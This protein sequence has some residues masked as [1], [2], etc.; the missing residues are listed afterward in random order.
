MDEEDGV[1]CVGVGACLA[2]GEAVPF[3]DV[4]GIPDVAVWSFEEVTEFVGSTGDGVDNGTGEVD[5][6][7][8]GSGSL[9]FAS[10]DMGEGRLR[11][12]REEKG[13]IGDS[14]GQILLCLAQGSMDSIG[15]SIAVVFGDQG[16]A[17]TGSEAGRSF[18]ERSRI[19]FGSWHPRSCGWRFVRCPRRWRRRL[20]GF[21]WHP[22]SGG[23]LRGCRVGIGGSL[24]F[25]I[26]DG[27]ELLQ[28]DTGRGSERKEW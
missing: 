21:I 9:L 16:G 3:F 6:L 15:G 22:R 8:G 17:A 20:I 25:G 2:L 26:E 19:G 28:L 27:S 4:G 7:G 11:L 14:G 13:C 23:G 1:D 12:G 18:F 24:S 5:E 10:D